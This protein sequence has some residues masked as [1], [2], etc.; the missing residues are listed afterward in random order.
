MLE[1]KESIL[2]KKSEMFAVRIIRMYK[3]L[4]DVKH[5][6]ILSKQILR[7]DTGIGANIAESRR[8]QSEHDFISK[9]HIALKEAEE[10][11]FWLKS[12]YQGEYISEQ[13]FESMTQ[14]NEELIRILVKSIKTMKAK[15]G[16]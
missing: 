13:G 5:E 2:M 12:L 9:L 15:I 10:T 4:K 6:N 11:D 8:A 16:K 3:Y 14:D 1:R 7:S